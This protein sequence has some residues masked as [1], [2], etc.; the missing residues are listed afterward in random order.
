MAA[1][2]MNI[3]I[4]GATGTAGSQVLEQ[5][6]LDPEIQ[7]VTA[8]SR[9][10]LP[11]NPKLKTILHQN[12]LDYSQLANVFKTQDACIW[13]LGISQTQVSKQEYE[14]ITFEY[15]MAC[16]EALRNA[17]PETTFVFLSGQGADSTEQSRTTFARIKGK[18]ENALQ[19]LGFKHLY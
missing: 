15:T 12:F 13:C 11:Q 3:L 14:M 6:L 4:T 10:S 8:L 17:N 2:P 18:T 5:A 9:K 7:T 19:R 1:V 16:A